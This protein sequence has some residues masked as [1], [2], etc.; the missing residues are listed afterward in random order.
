M[1]DDGDNNGKGGEDIFPF[2]GAQGFESLCLHGGYTPDET[3]SRGVPL[4]RTAPYQVRE[5]KEEEAQAQADGEADDDIE[6]DVDAANGPRTRE[7]LRPRRRKRVGPKYLT[8]RYL[9][10]SASLLVLVQEH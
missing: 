1:S 9:C 2:Q 8:P 4:Y 3:T 5:E 10:F 7:G 6:A